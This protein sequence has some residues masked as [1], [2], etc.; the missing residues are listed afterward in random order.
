VTREQ[1]LGAAA[2][3]MKNRGLLRATTREIAQETEYSEAAL[4]RTSAT[5]TI[6]ISTSSPGVYPGSPARYGKSRP[7]PEAWRRA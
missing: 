4:Y 6:F 3:V 5:K 1:M 7:T 2:R